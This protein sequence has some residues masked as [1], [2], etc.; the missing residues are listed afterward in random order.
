MYVFMLGEK[1][2]AERGEKHSVDSSLKQHG[3]LKEQQVN[4]ELL[5]H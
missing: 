5:K 3:V 1:W 4:L 2:Y